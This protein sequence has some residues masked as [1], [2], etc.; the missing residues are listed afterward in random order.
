[1]EQTTADNRIDVVIK[2]LNTHQLGD[3]EVAVRGRAATPLFPL[4]HDMYSWHQ[5]FKCF[6]TISTLEN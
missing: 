4:N 5:M 3:R 1:M 6:L 2:H